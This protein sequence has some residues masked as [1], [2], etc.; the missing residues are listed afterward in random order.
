MTL[1]ELKEIELAH[2]KTYKM[3]CAPNE[4]SNQPGYPPSPIKVFAIR[5]KKLRSLAT[6]WAHSEDSNQS[7]RIRP[8]WSE[9]SL[10][11]HAIMLVSS[12]ASSIN[13]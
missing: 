12:L 11:A 6:Q 9:S 7:G 5:M 1:S 2:D 13:F 8:D 4:D 3:A 10:G